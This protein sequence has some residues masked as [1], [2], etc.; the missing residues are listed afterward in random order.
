MSTNAT[1]DVE[2]SGRRLV[3]LLVEAT[4]DEAHHDERSQKAEEHAG[5]DE[6][7]FGQRETPSILSR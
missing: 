7:A 4:G 3:R 1:I 2:D 6:H 5:C